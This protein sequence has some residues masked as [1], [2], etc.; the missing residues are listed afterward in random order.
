MRVGRKHLGLNMF[1]KFSKQ[2]LKWNEGEIPEHT[3]GGETDIGVGVE[4]GI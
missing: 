4:A 3:L 1:E 2:R